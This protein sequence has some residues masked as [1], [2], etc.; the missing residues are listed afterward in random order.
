M[1]DVDS[2]NIRHG[3]SGQLTFKEVPGGLVV[4]EVAKAYATA[5]VAL[6]GGHLMRW[7]PHGG[8]AVI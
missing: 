5:S 1:T 3:I 4:A 7:T 8:Q 6:Q 2:L